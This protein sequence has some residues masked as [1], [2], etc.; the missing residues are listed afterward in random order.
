M[1]AIIQWIDTI[2]TRSCQDI[3]VLN[4]LSF[5]L[6]GLILGKALVYIGSISRR[7]DC[8]N[9]EYYISDKLLLPMYTVVLCYIPNRLK[10]VGIVIVSAFPPFCVWVQKRVEND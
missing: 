10:K 1:V 4:P 6:R 7:Y 8:K 5:T 2:E 9:K 3:S